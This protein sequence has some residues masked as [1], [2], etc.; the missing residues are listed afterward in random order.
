MPTITKIGRP[1]LYDSVTGD[2]VGVKD[3]D[4]SEHLFAVTD[5]A[6][7]L[8][9]AVQPRSNLLLSLQALEGLPG[10]WSYPTDYPDATVRHTGVAGQARTFWKDG[11]AVVAGNVNSTDEYTVPAGVSIKEL[12]FVGTPSGDIRVFLD[13]AQNFGPFTILNNTSVDVI[14][15]VSATTVTAHNSMVFDRRPNPLDPSTMSIV[16]ITSNIPYP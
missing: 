4:G 14:E 5:A 3:V 8:L 9:G 16:P 12:S 10:E 15:D 13:A 2:I 11:G 6:G 1:W 7:N